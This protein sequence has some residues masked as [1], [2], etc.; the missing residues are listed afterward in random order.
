MLSVTDKCGFSGSGEKLVAECPTCGEG[1]TTTTLYDI[2]SGLS[3]LTNAKIIVDAGDVACYGGA[4][5]T[6]TN[7]GSGGVNLSLAGAAAFAGTPGNKSGRE[8]FTLGAFADKVQLASQPA[9]AQIGTQNTSTT[10]ACWILPR[11]PTA[12][13]IHWGSSD[14][15]TTSCGRRDY[16]ILKT[17][18]AGPGFYY[19][20]VY[21]ACGSA[22]V[23]TQQTAVDILPSLV[24][25]CWNFIAFVLDDQAVNG[26]FFYANG[27]YAPSN[28]WGAPSPSA[29][30]AQDAVTASL[31]AS[32]GGY[33]IPAYVSGATDTDG[34]VCRLG[35]WLQWQGAAHAGALTKAQ[36]DQIYT[37]TKARYGH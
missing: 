36:L 2:L 35:A 5:S 13:A 21:G 15:S 33:A 25:N 32:V 28:S 14:N 10:I 23:W 29:H 34:R 16:N 3:L 30:T 1:G 18:D 19:E 6:I 22:T 27:A 4:G 37:A 7:R 26:T 12:T 20:G 24:W 31:I 11:K 8:F 9:W 17:G